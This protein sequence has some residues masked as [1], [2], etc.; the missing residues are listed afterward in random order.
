MAE[1]Y[2]GEDLNCS[3]AYHQV[4]VGNQVEMMMVAA[5]SF[6]LLILFLEEWKDVCQDSGRRAY[7]FEICICF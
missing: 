1:N 5:K 4:Q 3:M 6:K 7:I 2:E